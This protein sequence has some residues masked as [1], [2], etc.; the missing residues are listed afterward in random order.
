M[1]GSIYGLLL[2]NNVD[3]FWLLKIY[4]GN[5][6]MRNLQPYDS[7]IIGSLT[8]MIALS[9]VGLMLGG[10]PQATDITELKGERSGTRIRKSQDMTLHLT[11]H[12]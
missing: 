8:L 1:S 2:A 7:A 11:G 12:P 3:A 10:Q 9:G 5:F 4:T 6:G